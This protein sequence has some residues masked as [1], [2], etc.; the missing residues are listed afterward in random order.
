MSRL[1]VACSV[2]AAL[3]GIAC[4]VAAWRLSD[5]PP[6][7]RPAE[8][9]TDGPAAAAVTVP[10]SAAPHVHARSPRAA[11][12]ALTA[13]A[14]S[15][16]SVASLPFARATPQGTVSAADAAPPGVEPAAS[17]SGRYVR[18][19]PNHRG[20]SHVAPAAPETR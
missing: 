2:A 17:P 16:P 13:A 14:P 20:R 3:T 9:R 7:V 4:G 8:S 11:P 12:A 10:A 15:P 18:H 19:W 1:F 6:A 5:V